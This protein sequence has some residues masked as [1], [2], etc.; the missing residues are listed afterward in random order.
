MSEKA[1]WRGS[2]L[3]GPVPPVLVSCGSPEAPNLF[4]VAWAGT[5]CT[6]PPRLSISVRP[7]RHSYG[8]IRQSGEFVVNLPT[9]ALARAVDWCGV[10]SGRDLDKF[11]VL[12]LT[13]APASAVGCPLLAE[14]PVNLECRVFQTIPLGSHELF[15]ADVVAV[16]VDEALLDKEGKL[17]LEQA[18]LLAYAHGAY[19]A[20]GR[21]MGT[22]GWSVRK[23][24]PGKKGP[25]KRK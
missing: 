17:H 18:G 9:E 21:Q 14:S 5:I 20:L 1:I 10:K 11:A 13:A 12:R 25:A 3:L 16:D 24:K 8:L 15:L 23:K 22:F 2:A 7:S 4:T 6:Q 19:Y